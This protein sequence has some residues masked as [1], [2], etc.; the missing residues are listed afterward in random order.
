MQIFTELE[1][2]YGS[3]EESYKTVRK[4]RKK[5]LIDAESVKNAAKFVRLVTVTG[6]ANV[7]RVGEMIESI[8]RYT[9]CDIG[10]AIGISLSQ[11]HFMLKRI[12]K[13]RKSSAKWISHILAGTNTNR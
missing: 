7:S 1:K 13:V 11:V 5:F 12:L 8:G 10:K 6:K 4:W 2:L 3:N 9:I